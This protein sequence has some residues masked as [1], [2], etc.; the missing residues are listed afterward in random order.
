LLW[1]LAHGTLPILSAAFN[2]LMPA[3]CGGVTLTSQVAFNG[4]NVIGTTGAGGIGS[5]M[6]ISPTPINIL[7]SSVLSN[8]PITGPYN[9]GAKW[10]GKINVTSAGL[11]SFFTASDDGSMIFIDGQ[12]VVY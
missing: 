3:P 8:V 10:A 2:T 9:Y 6:G 7:G 4:I 11:T 1:L 5:F 12:P